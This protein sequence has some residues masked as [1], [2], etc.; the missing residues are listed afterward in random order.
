[1]EKRCFSPIHG[2]SGYKQEVGLLSH[3]PTATPGEQVIQSDFPVRW[4]EA[5]SLSSI[6]THRTRQCS[7]CPARIVLSGL[8]WELICHPL[9]E[10]RSD[11]PTTIV[12]VGCIVNR[13]PLPT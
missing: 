6:S 1:M 8:S 12:S 13:D 7:D 11:S 4:G 2:I 9:P 5:G 10:E 3:T